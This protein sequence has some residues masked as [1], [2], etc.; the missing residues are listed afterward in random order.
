MVL[1]KQSWVI[2]EVLTI[3]TAS[4]EIHLSETW[5]PHKESCCAEGVPPTLAQP[6]K[7]LLSLGKG[8]L[9][10][11]F[12]PNLILPDLSHKLTIHN[13]PQDFPAWGCSAEPSTRGQLGKGMWWACLAQDETAT[14][15][16]LIIVLVTSSLT[17]CN[18]LQP[19]PKALCS[20]NASHNKRRG[21]VLSQ[22]P[23][24]PFSDVIW[25]RHSTISYLCSWISK[26]LSF[27]NPVMPLNDV[28]AISLSLS[29]IN[30]RSGML[31]AV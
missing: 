16:M 14:N 1:Q 24:D 29:S 28:F 15:S 10:R 26:R 23:Q 19:F 13:Q 11:V 20:G 9:L 21:S 31:C 12:F 25:A 22:L 30:C 6:R 17:R 3:N 2:S 7:A 18:P 5:W 4:A 8:H 27:K